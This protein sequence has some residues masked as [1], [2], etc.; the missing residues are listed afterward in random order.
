MAETARIALALRMCPEVHEQ[1]MRD[2]I[3]AQSHCTVVHGVSLLALMAVRLVPLC[4]HELLLSSQREQF[5][6]SELFS[7]RLH[8]ALGAEFHHMKVTSFGNQQMMV[9]RTVV[10]AGPEKH[11]GGGFKTKL[12]FLVKVFNQ[13][14]EVGYM[15]GLKLGVLYATDI[16]NTQCT[17]APY[18]KVRNP[19]RLQTCGANIVLAQ[20]LASSCAVLDRAVVGFVTALAGQPAPPAALYGNSASPTLGPLS[21][22]GEKQDGKRDGRGESAPAAHM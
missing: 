18:I 20:P 16:K 14:D 10:V 2:M 12:G 3:T 7:N 6:C 22:L 13:P 11:K 15:P 5:H 21:V 1:R 19:S 8:E 4:W 17:L 9:L